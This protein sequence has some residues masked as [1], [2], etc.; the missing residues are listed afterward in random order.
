MAKLQLSP[1][2]YDDLLSIKE[3]ISSELENPDAALTTIKKITA[4]IRGLGTFPDRGAPLSSIIDLHTDYRFII[5]DSY[6][7]FYRR[8]GDDVYVVRVLYGRRD[9]MKILFD[10]MREED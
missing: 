4:A 10:I 9:Y 7:A 8:D 1:E 3:Y 2:V 5:C 6:L